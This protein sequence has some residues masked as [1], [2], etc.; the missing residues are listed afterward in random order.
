MGRPWKEGRQLLAAC[1]PRMAVRRQ[2]MAT[3]RPRLA[4]FD[5]YWYTLL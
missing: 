2:R 3:G 4:V 1:R 5:V